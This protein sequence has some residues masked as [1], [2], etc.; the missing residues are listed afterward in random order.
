MWRVVIRRKLRR[1]VAALPALVFAF[2]AG[3]AYSVTTI[4]INASNVNA[5]GNSD[6]FLGASM[7]SVGGNFTEVVANG[8]TTTV[9]GVSTGFVANEIDL[10]GERITLNFGPTGAVVNEVILGLLYLEGEW[11]GAADEAARLITNPGTVCDNGSTTSPCI[12]SATGVWRGATANVTQLSAPLEGSGGIFRIANPFGSALISTL[13]FLPAPI[14]GQGGA[15]SDFGIV[16][17][18]YTTTAI[19]EPGTLLLV[20]LGTLGLALA[21]RQRSRA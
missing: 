18:R 17:I 8:T 4:T 20:G 12:F 6:S 9:I 13:D 19:P 7:T 15:N 1:Y 16:S 10:D 14:S 2:V 21:G 3:P 5:G 11:G